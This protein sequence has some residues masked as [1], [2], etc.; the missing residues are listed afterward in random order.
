[1]RLEVF[2]IELRPDLVRE[3]LKDP[4]V[5][6]LVDLVIEFQ[7]AYGQWDSQHGKYIRE[8]MKKVQPGRDMGLN[9]AHVVLNLEPHPDEEVELKGK[10]SVRDRVVRAMSFDLKLDISENNLGLRISAAHNRDLFKPETIVRF[11]KDLEWVLEEF[12][13]NPAKRISE[14]DIGR[15]HEENSSRV[16]DQN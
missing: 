4:K 8:I 2:L 15:D 13:R 12:V 1:M 6:E 14:L 9:R 5:K 7:I 3:I 11:L 16:H 10:I